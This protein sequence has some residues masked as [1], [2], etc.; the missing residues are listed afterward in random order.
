MATMR[1]NPSLFGSHQ[2][3]SS[4]SLASS[5]SMVTSGTPRRSTRPAM[6][7]GCTSSGTAVACAS[8]SGGNSC[9]M[10]WPWI[11]ASTACEAV[12]LSPSTA[13]TRPIGGRCASCGVVTSATTSCPALAP[14]RASCGII[15]LRWMRLSSGTT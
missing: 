10:S 13:S 4:K 15:T 5:P 3:A 7:A 2:T 8:T 12:S 1:R 9:G 14:L 6:S 11:A